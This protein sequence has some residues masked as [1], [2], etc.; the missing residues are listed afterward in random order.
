[1]EDI[2]K[3]GD[4]LTA[5]I[6]ELS[7]AFPSIGRVIIN[8]RDAYMF[9]KLKQTASLGSRRILAVVGAGHCEGICRLVS[10]ENLSAH[11]VN[12]QTLLQTV[13]ETKEW[14]IDNNEEMR[15]LTTDVIELQV[16]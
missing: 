10:D 8:E 1:M 7:E 6:K 16:S 4:L 9:A 13:I 14:K 2:M 15:A 11:Q 12:T 5:S 3:D